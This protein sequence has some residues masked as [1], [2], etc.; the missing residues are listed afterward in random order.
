MG[1]GV[2][3]AHD[4]RKIDDPLDPH[5]QRRCK[6]QLND[7]P[8]ESTQRLQAQQREDQTSILGCQSYGPTEWR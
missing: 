1:M 5:D 8:R 6:G 2:L 4:F 3:W 7:R